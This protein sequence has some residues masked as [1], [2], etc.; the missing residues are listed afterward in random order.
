[1]EG[2]SREREE[3]VSA[4]PA[5]G[6]VSDQPPAGAGTGP[7]PDPSGPPVAPEGKLLGTV[8]WAMIAAAATTVGLAVIVGAGSTRTMGVPASTRLEWQERSEEI[9][10]AMRQAELGRVEELSSAAAGEERR[11]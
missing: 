8:G 6:S 3:A 10:E 5:Q 4:A 1:M 9:D 7:P 11:R 2:A